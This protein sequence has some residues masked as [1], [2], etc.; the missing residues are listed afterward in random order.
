MINP[1]GFVFPGQGS[2]SVGMLSDIAKAF[3]EVE[4]SFQEASAVLGYDVWKLVRLGP[5]EELDKTVRTQPALLAASY[6]IWQIIQSRKNLPVTLLAGHSLGEYT[7]L[8]CAKVIS[9]ADAIRLVAARGEYMQEAMPIGEGGLAAIIGLEDNDVKAICDKALEPGEVLSPANYNSPGQVVIAGH[10]KAVERALILAKEQGARMVKL[11]PVSVSSHCVLMK[12][13]A[14]KLAS[15]LAVMPMQR[16]MIPIIGNADVA[17]YETAAEIRE[18]L[19]KQLYSP[20]RWVETIR[21]F[22]N[23]GIKHIVECGPGKVLSS[24]N[25]RILSEIQLTST[26]DAASLHSLLNTHF[27][28][29]KAS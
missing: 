28:T 5:T 24:L 23:L 2:Q 3:S 18:G 1:I 15:L 6:A 10:I 13:A 16:P 19:I 9:F 8:V 17:I 12:P 7:A 26:T 25:K 21:L 29:Q 20:V 27:E 11:L 22:S 4:E 14:D